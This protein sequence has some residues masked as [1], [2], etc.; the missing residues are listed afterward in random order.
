MDFPK[1][2]KFIQ[3]DISPFEIGRN[4]KPD[5]AIIGDIKIVLR[6]LNSV[7]KKQLQKKE[8]YIQKPRVKALIQAKEEF[9]REVHEECMVEDIPTLQ[10][11]LFMK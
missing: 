1:G 3:V 10:S 6:Q 8:N 4:W 5:V 2:V 9:E 11:A 7:I